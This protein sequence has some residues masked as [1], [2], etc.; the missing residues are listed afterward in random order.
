V[1][2][3]PNSGKAQAAPARMFSI[4]ILAARDLH[5]TFMLILLTR[6][7]PLM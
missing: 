3:D 1:Q 4:A 2:V 7:K 5:G 6:S